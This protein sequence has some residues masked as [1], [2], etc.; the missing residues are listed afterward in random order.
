MAGPPPAVWGWLRAVSG[1]APNIYIFVLFQFV[2]FTII[3]FFFHLYTF[4][5]IIFNSIH[6]PKLFFFFFNFVSDSLNHSNIIL[7]NKFSRIHNFEYS[8]KNNKI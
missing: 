4:F 5:P 6:I 1:V 7:K 2:S 3:V 8:K